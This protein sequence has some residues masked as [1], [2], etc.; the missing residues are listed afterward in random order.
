[1]YQSL[2]MPFVVRVIMGAFH[3]HIFSY[4]IFFMK[5]PS[6]WSFLWLIVGALIS[7]SP[8][9]LPLFKHKKAL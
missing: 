7:E 8:N 6:N 4:D 1:M 2:M 9:N 3:Q 5:L